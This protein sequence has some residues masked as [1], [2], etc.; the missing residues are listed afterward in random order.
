VFCI[1]DFVMMCEVVKELGGDFVKINF[2]VFVEMVIDYF[3]IVDV[4]G[5][6]DV[7][8]CNVELEY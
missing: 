2:L 4:F 3:V 5:C 6:E 7:F 8:E 1:V